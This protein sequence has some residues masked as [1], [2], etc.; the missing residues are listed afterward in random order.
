MNIKLSAIFL[1]IALSAVSC[2]DDPNAGAEELMK[3]IRSDYEAGRDS[4]CLIA[5]DTLRAK[6]P[7]AI[8]ARKEALVIHQNATLRIAQKDLESTDKQL[9]AAKARY[10][11]LER[12]VAKHKAELC[13]TP[14][15][16]TALTMQR[17]LRDSLQTRFEVLCGQ[18]RFIHKKQN[19]N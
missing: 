19:A 2:K 13:A 17:I 6:Y 4:A 14:A 18:I 7:K 15:E 1:F 5:I 10:A 3:E 12:Q 16:L 8:E 9:E 11:E